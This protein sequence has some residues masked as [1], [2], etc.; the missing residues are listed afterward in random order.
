MRIF[1]GRKRFGL[2]GSLVWC[3]RRHFGVVRLS[4]VGGWKV[5]VQTVC[6]TLSVYPMGMAGSAGRMNL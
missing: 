4:S 6:R 5:S 2:K 3:G 1:L